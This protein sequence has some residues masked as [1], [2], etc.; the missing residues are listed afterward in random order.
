MALLLVVL[1]LAAAAPKLGGRDVSAVP[2][3]GTFSAPWLQVAAAEWEVVLGVWLLSGFARRAAWLASV[4][5]FVTFAGVSGY[6]GLQGVA[7][8]GCFGAIHASPWWA[9]GVDVVALVLL[10]VSRPRAA[11]SRAM[12]RGVAV[13]GGLA[14]LLVLASVAAGTWLYGSPAAALARLRGDKL[15]I[16]PDT[17]GFGDGKPGESLTAEVRVRN[18]T[19]RPVRLIGGTADCS[20]V[21]TSDLP[22]TLA[23]HGEAAIGVKLKLPESTGNFTR[24]AAIWTDCDD[25][26]S[27]RL[28]LGGRVTE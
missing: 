4:L 11:E 15:H 13:A 20:C 17:V 9:F 2:Q 3:A 21:T 27:L 23:P 6:L 18:F 25:Q 5:T 22:I 10:S 19:D 24:V 16:S 14:A 28:R 1:L 12:P 8:C 7:N 26:R